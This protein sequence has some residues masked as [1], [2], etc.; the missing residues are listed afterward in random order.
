MQNQL[1]S[2]TQEILSNSTFVIEPGVY[3]YTKVNSMPC[4]DEH[5]LVAKDADEITV[6]TRQGNLDKL[7]LIERN[8]D[9]Y[10]L[11]ALNVSI[12]F[13]SVGFLATV[14]SAFAAKGHNILIV[15]TYSK[16]YLMVRDDL[17]KDAEEILTSLGLK[18]VTACNSSWAQDSWH[19]SQ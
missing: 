1:S 7:D 15:S 4:K 6:V 16:D 8:K 12:P 5:F 3:I 19:E 2:E 18:R 9:D 10:C 11:I 17:R 14:S 13:Y